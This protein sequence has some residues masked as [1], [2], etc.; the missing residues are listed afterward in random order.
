MRGRGRK[1]RLSLTPRVAF[2]LHA[3]ASSHIPTE[4]I[5]RRCLNAIHC[6]E[7]A[8]YVTNW[9][10]FETAF[11]SAFAGRVSLVASR[12]VVGGGVVPLGQEWLS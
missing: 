11:L 6:I 2:L 9:A 1:G 12:W 5:C 10:F 7:R 8:M 4:A 3:H